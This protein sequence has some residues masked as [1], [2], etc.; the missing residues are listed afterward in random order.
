MPK[1]EILSEK[2]TS[3]KGNYEILRP[4]FQPT[5]LSSNIPASKLERG[6]FILEPSKLFFKANTRRSFLYILQIFIFLCAELS[7]SFLISQSPA[8]AKIFLCF[9]WPIKSLA[10]LLACILAFIPLQNKIWRRISNWTA[11]VIWYPLS[12]FVSHDHFYPMRARRN[13]SVRYNS[14]KSLIY[15]YSLGDLGVSSNLIGSLP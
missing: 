7:T 8:S 10:W 12:N 6:L 2:R 15:Q 4:I 3:F 14:K 13:Y 9:P 11:D 5:T 1:A